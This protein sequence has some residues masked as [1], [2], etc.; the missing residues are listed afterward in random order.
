M[1]AACFG[2]RSWLGSVRPIASPGPA[3]RKP[4]E[5]QD[6]RSAIG[7]VLDAEPN[8]PRVPIFGVAKDNGPRTEIDVTHLGCH[9]FANAT[10]GVE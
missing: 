7:C 1:P 6:A 8:E 2:R 4:S 9:Q 10:A 5:G 3:Y